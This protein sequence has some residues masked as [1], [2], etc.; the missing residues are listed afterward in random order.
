MLVAHLYVK[1]TSTWKIKKH[2]QKGTHEKDDKEQ[3]GDVHGVRLQLILKV[4][5]KLNR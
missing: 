4:V 5:C 2:I 3:N 1:N